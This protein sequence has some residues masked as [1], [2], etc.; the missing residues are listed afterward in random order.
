MLVRRQPNNECRGHEVHL[1]P[2]DRCETVRPHSVVEADAVALDNSGLIRDDQLSK[3]LH[4][5]GLL[6]SGESISAFWQ[7][8]ST[9]LQSKLGMSMHRA[10]LHW[11]HCCLGT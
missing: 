7:Q 11:C 4:M 5:T 9:F 1:I 10:S 2:N 6:H 3:D 8:N